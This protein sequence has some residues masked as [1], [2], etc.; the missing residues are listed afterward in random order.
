MDK[1]SVELLLLYLRHKRFSL[2]TGVC[3][4]KHHFYCCTCLGDVQIPQ[5]VPNLYEFLCSAEHKG[6]YSE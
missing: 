1:S 2:I 4:V 6:I 5:V 3:Q